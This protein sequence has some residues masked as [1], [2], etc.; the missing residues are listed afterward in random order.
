MDHYFRCCDMSESK[1]IR[2]AMMKLTGQARQYWEN[3]ERMMRYR[4][5]DLVKTWE[6]TKE[7]LRLKYIPPPFSQQLLD[8]WNR[9]TQ[10]NKSATDYIAKFDEYL[11]RCGAIE[12]ESTEQILSRFRSCLRDD[13]RWE[14]IARGITTPTTGISNGHRFRWV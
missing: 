11:N 8:K 12:F 4:R 7:K 2:F 13:Y 1:K 9:L 6:G 5:D 10:E 14:L 3:L